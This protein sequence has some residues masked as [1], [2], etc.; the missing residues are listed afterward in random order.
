MSWLRIDD[1][2]T[3][4]AKWAPL[5]GEAFKFAFRLMCW[6]AGKG[7]AGFV[8]ADMVRQLSGHTARKTTRLLEELRDAGKPLHQVGII[9]PAD[10]GWLIHDA[11]QYGPPTYDPDPRFTT[12][13]DANLSRKR[14]EAGRRGGRRSAE[15]KR[16][17]PAKQSGANPPSKAEQTRQA[18][19]TPLPRTPS[20]PEPVP[21][22]VPGVLNTHSQDLIGS[23][24]PGARGVSEGRRDFFG[25]QFRERDGIDAEVSTVFARYRDVLRKP[26][27]RLDDPRTLTIRELFQ[28]GATRQDFEDVLLE[29]SANEWYQG[30][31]HRQT[32]SFVF[33]NRER[34]ETLLEAGRQRRERREQAARARGPE[35]READEPEG[36]AVPM[37]PEVR[38]QL[39]ALTK[40]WRG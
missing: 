2:L 33:G 23:A 31:G 14:A 27:A 13:P 30:D 22:P 28:Q 18:N 35:I 5:S 36:E 6:A 17:K 10:G 11:D 34:Y 9:E 12:A 37:P 40:E 4:H 20:P 26:N 25:E 7:T 3:Q 19:D 8:P 15:A 16:S 39:E 1:G 32:V 38:E 21:V 29:V 24:G